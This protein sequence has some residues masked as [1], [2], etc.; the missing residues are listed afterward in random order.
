MTKKV[1]IAV[2]VMSGENSP[3]KIIEAIDIS[4]KSNVDNFF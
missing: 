4:L 1:K 3:K 2:D